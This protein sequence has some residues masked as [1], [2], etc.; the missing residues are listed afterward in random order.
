[1]SSETTVQNGAVEETRKTKK[2]NHRSSTGKIA[3]LP[4]DVREELNRRLDDGQPSSEIL[5]WVNGLP[6]TKAILDKYFRGVAISYRNITEWRHAGYKRW[7][8]KQES[9][10][11]LKWLVED[12]MDY[13]EVADGKL[14]RGAA[15]IATAKILKIL[16]EIPS[17]PESLDALSKI[18]YAVSALV[19]A[20]QGQVRLE[21][22]K[23]RVFQGNERLVLSW[24]KFLRGCIVTAQRALKDAIAKDIQ[25]S[26]LDN[27][28]KIELLGRRMFGKKWQGRAVGKKEEAEKK[29][30]EIPQKDSAES[31]KPEKT[32]APTADQQVRPTMGEGDSTEVRVSRVEE[33][34]E[35]KEADA[36]GKGR[37]DNGGDFTIAATKE[38]EKEQEEP[39]RDSA[40]AARPAGSEIGGGLTNRRYDAGRP[41]ATNPKQKPPVPEDPSVPKPSPWDA[42]SEPVKPSPFASLHG[43][44]R[45]SS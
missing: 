12:A 44:L 43:V 28:E 38:K 16:H 7:Q 6:A 15:S 37:E 9:V 32:D 20:E 19:N 21:H 2:K 31:A 42:F 14:A 34:T 40:P 35:V 18:S 24:D 30:P 36:P 23:T 33:K 22:E 17:T 13:S 1:M 41:M 39:M 26:N 27:G 4:K 25:A 45:R 8:E 29:E 5:P 3:R 10:D 11:E